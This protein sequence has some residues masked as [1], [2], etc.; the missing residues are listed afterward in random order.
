MLRR[1]N[2]MFCDTGIHPCRSDG[3]TLL[4]LRVK[5][6]GLYNSILITRVPGTSINSNTQSDQQPRCKISEGHETHVLRSSAR[7]VLLIV[8]QGDSYLRATTLKAQP[9]ASKSLII[10]RELSPPCQK[11]TIC[12]PHRTQSHCHQQTLQHGLTCQ[13]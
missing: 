12:L 8:C 4:Y 2:Y 1:T 5:S 7:S 9:L 3:R 13:C 10:S 11:S 6:T